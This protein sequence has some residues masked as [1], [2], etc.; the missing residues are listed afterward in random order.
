MTT[1]LPLPVAN[2]G[3]GSG[4]AQA[5]RRGLPPLPPGPLRLRLFKPCYSPLFSHGVLSMI[6]KRTPF[7]GMLTAHLCDPPARRTACGTM[8]RICAGG[9]TYRRRSCPGKLK[10]GY[11]SNVCGKNSDEMFRRWYF[12][13]F[14]GLEKYP[15]YREGEVSKLYW[16]N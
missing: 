5:L 7:H 2:P 14:V 12:L 8:G 16:K 13:K 1:W 9:S 3:P 6:E 11:S 15:E 4:S 10:T